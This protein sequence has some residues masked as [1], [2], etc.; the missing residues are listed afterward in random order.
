MRMLIVSIGTLMLL[1]TAHA[2]A[3]ERV[4]LTRKQ[5]LERVFPK[6]CAVSERVIS[7]SNDE[8]K[9]L[10]ETLGIPVLE[11]DYVFYV[12]R[13]EGRVIGRA[14]VMDVIGQYRPI[15]FVVGIHPEGSVARVDIMV[16]RETR[17][18]EVRRRAFLEQYEEKSLES[19]L[20][21][22]NDIINITGATLSSRHVTQGVRLALMLHARLIEGFGERPEPVEVGK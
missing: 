16:Y 14:V 3:Q 19:P 10:G 2:V 9:R 11:Q 13:H 6:G 18:S 17:G 15:T 7:I 5:A 12:A 20:R 1:G 4:Y 22:N 21:L 8:A